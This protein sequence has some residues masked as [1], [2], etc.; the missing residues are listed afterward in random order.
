[1][2]YRY[3]TREDNNPQ[4]KQGAVGAFVLVRTLA[5]L[6]VP[7]VCLALPLR[8]GG[9]LSF[10]NWDMLLQLAFGAMESAALFASVAFAVEYLA[11][12]GL[13]GRFPSSS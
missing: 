10:L 3:A 7:D 11:G 2:V 12:K 8:C 6:K 5:L 4:L 13:L 1:V 9:P